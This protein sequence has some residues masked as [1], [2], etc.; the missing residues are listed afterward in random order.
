MSGRSLVSAQFL[1]PLPP[2]VP[3]EANV[4]GMGFVQGVK[5]D[6]LLGD[7][8]LNAQGHLNGDDTL[9]EVMHYVRWKPSDSVEMFQI[10]S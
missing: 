10:V 5:R 2:M 4:A 7:Q 8:I 9:Q 1:W 6:V 3:L